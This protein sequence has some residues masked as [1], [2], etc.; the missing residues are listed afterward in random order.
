ML[1]DSTS[2]TNEFWVTEQLK[3]TAGS[4]SYPVEYTYDSQGKMKTMKTWQ[5]Y[6]GNTGTNTTTWVYNNERGWMTNKVYSDGNGPRYTHTPG[7]RLKTRVWA[8]GIT[9]TYKYGF[10]DAVSGIQHGD[11]T[12]TDY[13][14]STPDVTLTHDRLGRVKTVTDVG[15]RSVAYNFVSQATNDI[16]T[17]STYSFGSTN[18]FA[19]DTYLRLAGIT[20]VT[21]GLNHNYTYDTAGRLATA[22]DRTN[23][24][25]YTYHANSSLPAT[26]AFKQ[27]TTLRL[28]QTKA[29]DRLNRLTD[30]NSTPPGQRG[31]ADGL[32]LP[33][34]RRQPAHPDAPGRRQLLALRIRQSR[35]GD[36]RQ[37]FLGGSHAGGRAAV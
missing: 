33:V 25:N 1:P 17:V 12:V 19:Y 6:T 13:S 22:S 28:N 23:N 7:G 16:Y 21:L 27:N 4:R 2:T 24:V 10:D 32:Q 30:I 20:N 18:N 29:F 31:A 9:T 37:T 35:A 11:L 14:D 26:L 5:D 15:A 34:Q 36:Q 3:K 8:R